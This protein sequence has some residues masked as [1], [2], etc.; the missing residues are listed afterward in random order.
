MAFHHRLTSTPLP[1]RITGL[2]VATALLIAG[3]LAFMNPTQDQAVVA[4]RRTQLAQQVQPLTE[5]AEVGGAPVRL[6]VDR[7]EVDLPVQP[8]TYDEQTKEWTLT[9]TDAFFA[10]VSDQPRN[11]VGSTFIYGHNR[12]TAFGPLENLTVGDVVRVTTESGAVLTYT[13]REDAVVTPDFTSVLYEDADVPQLI[14]MTCEGLW[15]EVRRVM[16][17]TLSEATA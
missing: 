9:D 8:G 12:P 7:L 5:Q 11:R 15:S 10:T 6:S 4:E 1:I 2:Y 17:F 16:Y 3:L 14:L 13:Y